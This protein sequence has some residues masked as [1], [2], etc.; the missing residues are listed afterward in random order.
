MIRWGLLLGAVGTEVAATLSL[1]AS[2][3]A[4]L[5]LVVVV[6]G[7][8]LAFTFLAMVL[9]RGMPIGVAYGI[10]SASGV[11]LTALLA[12]L[13]FDEPLT[14]V[15]GVG[16]LAI[17]AGVL[18]VELGSDTPARQTPVATSESTTVPPG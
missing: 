15:M 6:V 11:A 16:L 5:W 13:L 9:E 10:W 12:Y 4:H 14:W 17:A 7:Y 18:L 1:R 2:M 3:D 8:V